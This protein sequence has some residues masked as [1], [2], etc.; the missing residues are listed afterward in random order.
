ML[1]FHFR[2]RVVLFTLV[3]EEHACERRE[4]NKEMQHCATIRV[5]RSIMVGLRLKFSCVTLSHA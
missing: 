2:L 3:G 5:V 4:A 1:H